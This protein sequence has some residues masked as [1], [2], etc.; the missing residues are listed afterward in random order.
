MTKRHRIP[1]PAVLLVL[2]LAAVLLLSRSRQVPPVP[3][4]PPPTPSSLPEPTPTPDPYRNEFAQVDVSRLDRGAVSVRYTGGG[5]ARIKVQITRAEGKNY[6]YDLSADG[7]WESFTLTEGE[8]EYTLRVMENTR[9][10]FYRQVFSCPLTLE[11]ADPAE[12][13][14][15][16]SQI[17]PFTSDSPAALL[18][19]RLTGEM[20]SQEEII[21]A[22]FDYVVDNLTYDEEKFASVQP[23]YLPDP[24]LTLEEGKGICYDYAALMT[25]MLRSRG[26]ACRLVKGWS[27]KQYHAWVEVPNGEGGWRVMDPTYV[28]NGHRSREILDYVSDPANYEAEYY[29]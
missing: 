28:S 10:E 29:L 11:L 14:R 20:E 6:N 4:P 13:F 7:R 18:A 9:E 8:G 17:V 23:G 16:A 2:L 22:V 26:V 12:P 19:A 15:Q 21:G 27:G 25:A 1:W 5:E 24:D 3:T